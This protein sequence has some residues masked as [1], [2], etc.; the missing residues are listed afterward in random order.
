MRFTMLRS[1]ASY[2][3]AVFVTLLL[4]STLGASSAVAVDYRGLSITAEGAT[5]AR[6][7]FNLHPDTSVRNEDY[8]AMAMVHPAYWH[9]SSLTDNFEGAYRVM[10]V[11]GWTSPFFINA[12]TKHI[13]SILKQ[14]AA[15]GIGQVVNLGAGYDSRPYRYRNTMPG[16]KFFEVELPEMVAEKKRRLR[17]VLGY[18]PEYVSFVPIDFNKQTISEELKE[19]G[20]NANVKTLFIWEGVTMYIS[21][22]AVESTLLFIATQSAPGSSVVFDYMPLAIIDGD[23]K[24]YT[25]MR[26]LTL[27]ARYRG[28]PLVFGIRG[29]DGTAYVEARD[30]EVLSDIGPPELESRYLTRIDGRLDGRCATGFRIMHAGVPAD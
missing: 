6:A 25:D 2:W 24:D 16:V 29:G 18:V 20:Y 5:A 3:M 4:V 17:Q 15:D 22:E 27:W 30:L 7:I 21:A 19:A 8:M 1:R 14:A 11:F 23:F 26:S 10:K 12:R 9:Y 28:E 13:D